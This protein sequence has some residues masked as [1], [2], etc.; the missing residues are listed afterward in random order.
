MKKDANINN[1]KMYVPKSMQGDFAPYFV[2][3]GIS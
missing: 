1:N 2:K 3:A